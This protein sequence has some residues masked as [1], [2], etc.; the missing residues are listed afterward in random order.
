MLTFIGL[1]LWKTPRRGS[2]ITKRGELSG[3]RKDVKR[4]MVQKR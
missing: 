1:N 3:G 2:E 4:I